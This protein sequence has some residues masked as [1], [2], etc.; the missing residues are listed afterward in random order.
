MPESYRH[1]ISR[2]WETPYRITRIE[3]LLGRGGMSEVYRAS[4]PRL[5]NTIALK[6]LTRE[7]GNDDVFRARFVRESP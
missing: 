1:F 5:G 7:L 6:L 3:G 4:N 2:D